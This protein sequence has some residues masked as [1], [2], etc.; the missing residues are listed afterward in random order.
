[1]GREAYIADIRTNMFKLQDF[2]QL[3]TVLILVPDME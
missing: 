3:N 2:T 1:M